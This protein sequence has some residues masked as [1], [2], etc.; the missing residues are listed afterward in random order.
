MR[1]PASLTQGVPYSL[2]SPVLLLCD[3][4]QEGLQTVG[5]TPFSA[6]GVHH[7]GSQGGERGVWM[8]S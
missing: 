3:R 5:T 1:A 2:A 7:G 6:V 4:I 8:E